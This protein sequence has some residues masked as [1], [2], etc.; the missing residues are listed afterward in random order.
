M[1]VRISYFEHKYVL[2]VEKLYFI[3]VVGVYAVYL[4]SP[5]N[6]MTG[7]NIKSGYI[8]HSRIGNYN[9]IWPFP[10]IFPYIGSNI[11]LNRLWNYFKQFFYPKYVS[12]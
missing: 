1:Y 3:E 7:L 5:V 2:R 4:G 9:D 12:K 8:E 10:K 6:K 11:S